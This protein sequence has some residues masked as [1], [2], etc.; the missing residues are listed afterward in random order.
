M[1][2]LRFLGHEEMFRTMLVED[3]F[4]LREIVKYR[5]QDQFPSM[6]IIEATDGMEAFQKI[7]GRPPNLIFMDISL[8]GETGLKLTTRIKTDY[9]DV[10]IIILTGEDSPEYREAAA[11]YKANYFFSKG[12][13][14]TDEI[15]KLVKSIILGKGFNA[16][17][18]DN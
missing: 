18:S 14:A 1:T 16:D 13:I 12:A 5:L 8:P 9:P 4:L 6:D 3:S 17:G 10:T 7:N 15:L 2:G 11:R